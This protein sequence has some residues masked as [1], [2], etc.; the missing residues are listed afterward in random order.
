MDIILLFRACLVN[1]IQL[2]HAYAMEQLYG[3]TELSHAYQ[4]FNTE[5]QD[6]SW[7]LEDI[8]LIRR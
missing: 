8:L 7:E 2:F 1:S 4:Q 3:V 6:F 5:R